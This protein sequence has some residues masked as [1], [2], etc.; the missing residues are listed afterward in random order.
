MSQPVPHD[1]Q[2]PLDILLVEDDKDLRDSLREV[3]EE[4]GYRVEAVPSGT[5]AI[6]LAAHRRFDLIVTDIKTPG[7]DGLTALEQVKE[8]NPEVSGIVI[9]GY[10][11]E[12]F[13]LRAARLQVENY[14]KKPF[15]IDDFLRTVDRLAEKKRRAQ[16]QLAREVLYAEALRCLATQMAAG[17]SQRMHPAV[18][19]FSR[20]T[21]SSSG[22]IWRDPRE[23]L[24]LETLAALQVS[25]ECGLDWPSEFANVFPPRVSQ[26]LS[27]EG[28]STLKEHLT[29]SARN[30]LAGH[31]MEADEHEATSEDE[32]D[33]LRGSLLNVALLLESAERHAEA[34]EAFQNLLARSAEPLDRYLAYFGLARLARLHQRS[35]AL[36]SYTEQ[37]VAEGMKLGPLTHSQALAERAIMLASAGSASAETA[38]SEAWTVARQLKDSSSY[39]LVSL[40]QEHFLARPAANKSR[41][42]SYLSQPEQFPLATE[43]SDWLLELLLNQVGPSPEE[44]R[45]L[46]KLLRASPA[47]FERL[48]LRGADVALL[49]NALPHL[50]IL[51]PERRQRVLRHLHGIDDTALAGKVAQ[52]SGTQDRLRREK[53]VLRVFS[54]SGIRLYRDDEALEMKRK[55]PL[56]LLLYLLY[57]NIPVGEE[58]LVELFWPGDESKA[59]ASL[60]TN[61]SY[62]RKLLCPDGK[63]DPFLRQAGGLVLSDEISIWFDFREFDQLVS[64]GKRATANSPD[65]TGDCFRSAVRLYR[66]PFLENIYEDWALQVRDQASLAYEHCLNYLATTGLSEGNWAQA[67]EYATRGLRRDPLSQSFCEMTMQAQIGLQR[68]HDALKTFEQCESAIRLELELEPSTDMIRYR[69]TAKLS[70]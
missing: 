57:R 28:D 49:S 47:A 61:L 37:A 26:A 70:L 27:N 59:R 10:S 35:E 48:L 51:G 21:A 7:T 12:E 31:E 2:D 52:W 43:A 65:R 53:T 32:S 42:L 15:D 66:G 19:K 63:L 38:L 46:G 58:N 23:Q 16:A 18:E 41:L 20:Q 44:Q 30:F 5:D 60:R 55:K 29:L 22:S 34:Q 45:F 6:A 50:E 40:A 62:L 67:F 1:I 3:L 54:F 24:A 39:A 36:E 56:L 14:L 9:T 8:G 69:E 33:S 13:A 17:H 25:V 64:N 68:Y 4:E 11:T